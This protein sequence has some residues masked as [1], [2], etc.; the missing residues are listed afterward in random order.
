M[1]LLYYRFFFN[2]NPSFS[3]QN[4]SLKYQIILS[5]ALFKAFLRLRQLHYARNESVG[6][7]YNIKLSHLSLEWKDLSQ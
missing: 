2:D 3:I 7:N 5:T 4:T 1:V 6:C